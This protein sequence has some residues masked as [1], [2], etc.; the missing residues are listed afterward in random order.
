MIL[1]DDIFSWHSAL[2]SKAIYFEILNL[3]LSADIVSQISRH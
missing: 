2:T 1:G 3:C